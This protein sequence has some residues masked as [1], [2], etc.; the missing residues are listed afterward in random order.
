[1]S[2]FPMTENP[3]A[4]TKARGK[5]T[6]DRVPSRGF[7][8]GV[9]VGMN[10]VAGAMALSTLGLAFASQAFGTWVGV[11]AGATETSQRL[12][13]LGPFGGLPERTPADRKVAP[14]TRAQAAAP[15]EDA[16]AK[17][18]D[19][20]EAGA[21]PVAQAPEIVPDLREATEE[22]KAKPAAKG[23]RAVKSEP[24]VKPV[25]QAPE[26]VPEL[27]EATEEVKAKPAAKGRRAVKSEPEVKAAPKVEG[28]AVAK[29]AEA[30]AETGAKVEAQAE[31]PKAEANIP[32][33]VEAEAAPAAARGELA[34]EA[35]RAPKPMERP[36]AP[37]DLK[38]ISGVGPK[39]EKVLNDLGIWTYAQIA[40]LEREEIA[41]IDD[42]LAFKG[43]IE[44]DDWLAQASK[45]AGTGVGSE[46]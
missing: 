30:K 26:I 28:K 29:P 4:G 16:L 31:S 8:A 15:V 42:Y 35:F 17:D 27:R 5:P 9:D 46:A 13:G 32:A 37:D 40:A 1:M 24:E 34:P 19:L 18:G 33:S 39:L 10:P 11:I 38:A 25:A 6:A 23:R 45:L 3:L 44:R 36:E 21:K 2:M 20:P 14:K 7:A 12:F 43:R 41:W 22:V